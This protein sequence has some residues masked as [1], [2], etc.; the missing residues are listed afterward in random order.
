MHF[1][2]L[3]SSYEKKNP[4]VMADRHHGDAEI[5]YPSTEKAEHYLISSIFLRTKYGVDEMCQDL[6]NLVSKNMYDYESPKSTEWLVAAELLWFAELSAVLE[7]GR[8]VK[9]D[10]LAIQG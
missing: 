8:P 4:L 10:K 1:C 9:T 6:W 7:L 3:T 5:V 2:F